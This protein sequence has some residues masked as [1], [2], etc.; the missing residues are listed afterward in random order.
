MTEKIQYKTLSW[1]MVAVLMIAEI[2]SNGMLS[3]PSSLAVVGIVPGVILIVFLGVFATYTSYLLIQ[4]K[5]NHPEVHNMGDAGFILFGR[6]GRELL[7]FG[8][9]VFAVFA[10]GGQLLAGQI[11][12]ASLSGSKLCLMLYTGIFA[13]PTLLFAL[14]RTLDRLTWLSVAS[15]ICIIVAG[16]VGMVGAG[17]N[18]VEGRT[19][20]AT[21][22]TSF[23]TAFLSITNPVFS[24]AG[25]F[26]FFILVSEMRYSETAMKAAYSLQA[27]ATIFYVVFAVVMYIYIGETVASPAFSSLPPNWQKAAYGIAIPNFLIAGSLYSHTA[28]KLLFI[29]FFRGTNDLHSHTVLGWTSWILLVL[30]M[31]GA[32]FVLAIA[33]PIFSYLIGIAAALFASWYTYGLAGA[34]WLYDSYHLQGGRQAWSRYWVKTT[35]NVLT[36]LAGAF[37]CVAGTYVTIKLIVDAYHNGSVGKPFS[38]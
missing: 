37:I 10:T 12:L 25:H 15:V 27:F 6:F 30:L 8:T 26:M 2:V 35:L 29:R 24:Y 3:L 17:I 11:A 33:V 32:A 1:E 13:V 36:L 9:I 7:S 14:P 31:N 38:C 20:S 19:I 5:L 21:V 34:F 22:P 18:P 16:I 23:V 4:F 28:A